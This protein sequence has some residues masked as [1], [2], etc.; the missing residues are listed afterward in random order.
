MNYHVIETHQINIDIFMFM[1]Y[2]DL[3]SA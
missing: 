1:E 2:K 3:T